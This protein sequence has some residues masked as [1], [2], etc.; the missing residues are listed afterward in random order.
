VLLRS[1]LIATTLVT[2]VAA[3]GYAQVAPD[4][5]GRKPVDQKEG[6]QTPE[7]LGAGRSMAGPEGT[8]QARPADPHV[9]AQGAHQPATGKEGDT[10]ATNVKP[11]PGSS[12]Q[13][14]GNGNTS[15]PNTEQATP[16][17]TTDAQSPTNSRAGGGLA[18]NQVLVEDLS[19]MSVNLVDKEDFGKVAGTVLNLQTGQVE[20]LLISTGGLLGVI[21]DALYEVPWSK[22]TEINKGGKEI[23]I[24]A[25]QAEIQPGSEDQARQN[26]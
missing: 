23:R 9:Q 4:M 20:K 13:P 22:V 11:P 12:A 5:G 14:S 8:E 24:N 16:T 21:G 10:A 1:M 18:G 3:S 19:E 7:T 6:V 15:R 26:D 17:N 25:K 2:T